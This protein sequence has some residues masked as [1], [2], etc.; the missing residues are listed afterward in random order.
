MTEVKQL[1]KLKNTLLEA[2][3]VLKKQEEEDA[4]SFGML[5]Y[6]IEFD[7]IDKLDKNDEVEDFVEEVLEVRR[8]SSI[9]E[10]MK[11]N[12]SLAIETENNHS[13]IVLYDL[14]DEIAKGEDADLQRMIKGM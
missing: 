11:N 2:N 4:H 1:D 5:K 12:C 10:I 6:F 9:I 14:I 3:R 13:L 8:P 7:I